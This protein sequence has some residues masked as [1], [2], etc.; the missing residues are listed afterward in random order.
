MGARI[1]EVVIRN[2]ENVLLGEVVIRN[3]ENVLLGLGI[4]YG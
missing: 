1:C 4:C 3:G 2:G